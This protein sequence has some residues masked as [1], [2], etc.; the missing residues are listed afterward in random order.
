MATKSQNELWNSL[1]KE[2][3]K[4]MVILYNYSDKSFTDRKFK[5]LE[6]LYG[7]DNLVNE[8]F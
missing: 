2:T 6:T 1:N 7:K 5:I 8:K 3:K 4:K